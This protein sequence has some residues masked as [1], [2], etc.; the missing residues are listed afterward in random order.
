MNLGEFQSLVAAYMTRDSSVFVV[1]SLNLI[2]HAAN[3]AKLDAQRL[4]NFP[5]LKTTAFIKANQYGTDWTSLKATPN[6]AGTAVSAH[7]ILGAYRFSTVGSNYVKVQ[8]YEV[9]SET[10]LNDL[11]PKSLEVM[12]E[13]ADSRQRIYL[14]GDLLK[15]TGVTTDTWVMLDII[16]WSPEYAATLTVTDFFLT[17]YHDWML[18]KTIQM[19]N[20]H[21]KE[22]QRVIISN[23]AMEQRWNSVL[24]DVARRND[25]HTT[26]NALD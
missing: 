19:L 15:L 16:Q 10:S 20:F 25:S 8:P 17:Q 26:A 9:I 1:G 22:D 5:Q 24:A 6:D 23:A 21:L 2:T 18:L 13:D 3:A 12:D 14:A 11:L 7:Y 4:I